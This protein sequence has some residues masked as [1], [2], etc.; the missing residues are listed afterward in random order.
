MTDPT[1]SA[2]DV[3]AR[4]E[5]LSGPMVGMLRYMRCQRIVILLWMMRWNGIT[6]LIDK[7]WRGNGCVHLSTLHALR[8]RGLV[9]KYAASGTWRLSSRGRLLAALADVEEDKD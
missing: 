2:F 1:P 7:G 4:H 3:L 6:W 5:R 9:E 8:R